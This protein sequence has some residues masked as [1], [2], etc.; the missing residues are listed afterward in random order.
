M[1]FDE[2]PA[3]AARVELG[4]ATC[5][6]AAL[7]L[8]FQSSISFFLHRTSTGTYRICAAGGFAT[9]EEVR[10]GVGRES[11]SDY[12]TSQYNVTRISSTY[13]PC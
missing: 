6:P 5:E 7:R 13:L 11:E 10:L 8:L 3:P 12:R 4:L 1:V 2:P 9:E